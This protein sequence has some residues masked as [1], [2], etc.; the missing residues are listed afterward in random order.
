MQGPGPQVEDW[1]LAQAQGTRLAAGGPSGV[2][3]ARPAWRHT[4]VISAAAPDV[5]RIGSREG[6]GKGSLRRSG[7]L[8]GGR[9][10]LHGYGWSLNL[11]QLCV[12]AES[13]PLPPKGILAT[14]GGFSA[15]APAVE[16]L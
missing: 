5:A 7:L 3:G 8:R 2:Q 12:S 11:P 4:W 15:S 13:R 9:C 1:G 14:C 16:V 6:E 10:G